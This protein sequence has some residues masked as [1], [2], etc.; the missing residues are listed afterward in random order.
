MPLSPTRL[1]ARRSSKYLDGV[2]AHGHGPVAG[3]YRAQDERK[4]RVCEHPSSATL[5]YP[6]QKN[7]QTSIFAMP[8]Q[9]G[10]AVAQPVSVDF[11]PAT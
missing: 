3:R 4:P 5:K 6:I 11:S 8:R 10:G 1:R 9:D 2:P 7:R